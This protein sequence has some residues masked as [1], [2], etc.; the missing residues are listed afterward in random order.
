MPDRYLK[1]FLVIASVAI[2]CMTTLVA[3]DSSEDSQL[4]RRRLKIKGFHLRD[5]FADWDGNKNQPKAVHYGQARA[6]FFNDGRFL[7]WDAHH[8][9]HLGTA[10]IIIVFAFVEKNLFRT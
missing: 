8:H 9:E 10:V 3:L 5:D 4:L 2:M 7:G 6:T 1:W